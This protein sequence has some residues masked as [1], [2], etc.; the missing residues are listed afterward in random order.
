M[1]PKTRHKRRGKPQGRPPERRLADDLKRHQLAHEVIPELIASAEIFLESFPRIAR[2]RSVDRILQLSSLAG[3]VLAWTAL[4][5]PRD[6]NESPVRC[7]AASCFLDT[8]PHRMS[9]V[10]LTMAGM[11]PEI[12]TYVREFAATAVDRPQLRPTPDL[13]GAEPDSV[14]A[15]VQ[16]MAE[17]LRARE[18]TSAD[19]LRLG[20][21]LILSAIALDPVLSESGELGNATA[22]GAFSLLE[23]SLLAD[24]LGDTD[25]FLSP[26]EAMA[27]AVPHL[28]E[29]AA[30][31]LEGSDDEDED[32]EEDDEDDDEQE[33]DDDESLLTLEDGLD[34]VDARLMQTDQAGEGADL[35]L[36]LA[37][38]LLIHGYRR[39]HWLP[40]AFESRVRAAG[41]ALMAPALSDPDDDDG[42]QPR[43]ACSQ[44]AGLLEAEVPSRP[45]SDDP[46]EIRLTELDDQIEAVRELVDADRLVDGVGGV[47]TLIG[48]AV[49]TLHV[50]LRLG[51]E[52]ADQL[53][54]MAAALGLLDPL[55]L[56]DFP[57]LRAVAAASLRELA[58]SPV[59]VPY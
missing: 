20:R 24:G 57:E 36:Q 39:A 56:A 18:A 34:A 13:L 7:F 26:L 48:A 35:A 41:D 51:H 30:E 3:D 45:P 17:R 25:R 4:G 58:R 49:Q 38:L 46:V 59:T 40:P 33:E 54:R 12:R 11:G 6:Q 47:L 19:G 50:G 52:D 27:D 8:D 1:A 32:E 28:I 16:A 22:A 5:A 37:C 55:A 42:I 14:V 9:W 15:E 2:R 44:A 29:H 43:L 21:Q 10:A 53:R 31:H 23:G